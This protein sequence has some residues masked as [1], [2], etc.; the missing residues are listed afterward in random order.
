MTISTACP[1]PLDLRRT[2]ERH[3]LNIYE[4]DG[5]TLRPYQQWPGFYTLP[6]AVRVPAV[7]IVGA[8]MVPSNWA[9]TG[10]ECT[11]EDTPEISTL[12][13][14]VSVETWTVRFTNYGSREGTQMPVSMRDISRRLAR[15]FPGDSVTP[16]PRTEST[17]EAL[18][19]RIRGVVSHPPIP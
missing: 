13:R 2:I 18:T 7:Y 10:I 17:Y 1:A 16:M 5:S 19:A 3:I 8:A 14:N 12:G 15:A 11:V 6:N 9:I 4:A